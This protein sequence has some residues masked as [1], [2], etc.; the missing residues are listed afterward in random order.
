MYS[1][2]ADSVK[3][4]FT[5]IEKRTCCI[6]MK[7]N[8]GTVIK[9]SIPPCPSVPLVTGQ[10]CGVCCPHAV[11]RLGN[12]ACDNIGKDMTTLK[13]FQERDRAELPGYKNKRTTT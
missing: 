12:I 1:L 5:K 9:T 4:P 6:K 2:Y 3:Q 7:I 10:L 11:C 13:Q 8:R